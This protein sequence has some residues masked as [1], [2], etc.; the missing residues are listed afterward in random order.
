MMPP[1]PR[2][3]GQGPEARWWD[4]LANGEFT[5]QSCTGCGSSQLPPTVVCRKC[6]GVAGALMRASGYG[7]VYSTTTVRERAGA[8]NV[9]IVELAEGPRLMSRIAGDPDAVQIGAAIRARIEHAESPV[10]VFDIEE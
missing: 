9:A 8:Y 7:T 6:G 4:L 1:D 5:V 2:F 10:L 3:D